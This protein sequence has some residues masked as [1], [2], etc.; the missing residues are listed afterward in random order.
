MEGKKGGGKEEEEKEGRKRRRRKRR[1]GEGGRREGVERRRRKEEGRGGRVRRKDRKKE[2]GEMK[3]K[4]GRKRENNFLYSG[5]VQ[6]CPAVQGS[7]APLAMHNK[8]L[9]TASS[10]LN[11]PNHIIQLPLI[12]LCLNIQSNLLHQLI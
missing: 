8:K 12:C 1:E 3:E 11:E 4:R 9:Q 2:R 5:I 10:W 7:D 6:K